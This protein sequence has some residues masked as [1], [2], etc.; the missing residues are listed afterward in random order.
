MA[1]GK[2]ET[3]RYTKADS[4]YTLNFTRSFSASARTT[5]TATQAGYPGPPD[6]YYATFAGFSTNSSAAVLNIFDPNAT[7]GETLLSNRNVGTALSNRPCNFHASYIREEMI[8]DE[9]NL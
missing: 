3:Y 1:S 6:G 7:E 4:P 5:T 9:R 2:I 8:T